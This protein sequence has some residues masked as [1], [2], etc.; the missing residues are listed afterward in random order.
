MTAQ[1]EFGG[2]FG[3]WFVWVDDFDVTQVDASKKFLRNRVADE[4]LKLTVGFGQSEAS[5]VEMPAFLSKIA[6]ISF[7]NGMFWMITI[8]KGKKNRTS[9][10]DLFTSHSP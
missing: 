10:I 9:D 6:K 3:G 5:S 1:D 4:F 7:S 2:G 8:N